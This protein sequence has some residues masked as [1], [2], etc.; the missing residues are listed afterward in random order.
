MTKKTIKLTKNEYVA[1]DVLY[2]YYC[3]LDRRCDEYIETTKEQKDAYKD[4]DNIRN[5]L[6]K[7][8][9]LHN[10]VYKTNKKTNEEEK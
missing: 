7:L 1:V 10:K 5:G 9:K 3:S 6:Y 4:E 8:L 2:S